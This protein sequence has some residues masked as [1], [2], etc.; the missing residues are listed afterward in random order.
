MAARTAAMSRAPPCA[1]E[2]MRLAFPASIRAANRR[3]G[4][5]PI[6]LRKLQK[7]Q[8]RRRHTRSSI[9][10]YAIAIPH[11]WRQEPGRVA[12]VADRPAVGAVAQAHDRVRRLQDSAETV[13]VALSLAGDHQ[14]E[15]TLSIVLQQQ[16]VG[17]LSGATPAASA[18]PSML[19]SIRGS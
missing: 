4:S 9:R 3:Q 6:S 15:L 18:R 14:V 12:R 2:P 16:V 13:K 7:S 8:P 11:L 10:C 1:K 19:P 17:Q 5:T